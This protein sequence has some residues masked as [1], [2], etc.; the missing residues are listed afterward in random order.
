MK[1]QVLG[2]RGFLPFLSLQQTRRQARLV[3][4]AENEQMAPSSDAARQ[5]Q[6][7]NPERLKVSQEACTGEVYTLGTTFSPLLAFRLL[8]GLVSVYKGSRV[9]VHIVLF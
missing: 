8:T 9:S 7:P 5:S 3:R 2:T 6:S 1:G 4:A